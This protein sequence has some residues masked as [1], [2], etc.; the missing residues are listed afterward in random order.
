MEGVA[1][2]IRN[3]KALADIV[4]VSYHWGDEYETRHNADQEKRATAAID[5][6]ADLIIG[7]HPHVVQEVVPYKH[8]Y[9]AYSLG[10]FV[11]D[12]NFSP[13]TSWGLTLKVT[14][15]DKKIVSVEEVPV[16][17]N[18]TYQPAFK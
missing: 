4:V 6:G 16:T 14:V 9:I 17:F 3:A 12:Q 15:K 7:H 10:N 18:K 2:D 1:R 13:D 5:A 11:F 8:G